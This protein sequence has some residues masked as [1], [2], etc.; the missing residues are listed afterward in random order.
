MKHILIDLG[1]TVFYNINL[2]FDQGGRYLYDMIEGDKPAWDDFFMSF[3]S[4]GKACYQGRGLIEVPFMSFLRYLM[5]LKNIHF[6]LSLPEIE[7]GFALSFSKNEM[8]EDVE[9][10]L[11]Y[12]QRH[13]SKVVALSNSAFQHSTLRYQLECF[14]I[15]HYFTDV[16]SSADW[17]FRKPAPEFFEIGVKILGVN[18]NN[19]LFIGNDYEVD[20]LGA[21]NAHLQCAWLRNKDDQRPI[22]F[23]SFVIE[24]YQDLLT[25]MKQEQ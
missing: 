1:D 12:C 14:G 25:L 24:S 6:A 19:I 4:L 13:H 20:V 21:Q 11:R 2:S 18:R 22:I 7:K 23:P 16:L 10:F 9:K 8:V 3:Q 17:I 5:A 15:L